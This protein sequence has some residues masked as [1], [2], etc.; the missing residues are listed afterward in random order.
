MSDQTQV[1]A[2]LA[3]DQAKKDVAPEVISAAR[4]WIVK[5]GLTAPVILTLRSRPLF[6]QTINCSAW[7]SANLSHHYR[8]LEPEPCKTLPRQY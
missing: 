5:A 4:R 2:E 8:G 7:T 3:K 1:N 6:A